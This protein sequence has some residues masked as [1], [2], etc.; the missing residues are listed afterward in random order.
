MHRSLRRHSATF[1]L[2]STLIAA[3]W[4]TASTA[5]GVV[6]L[7]AGASGSVA[8]LAPVLAALPSGFA[9]G[10]TTDELLQQPDGSAVEIQRF[11]ADSPHGKQSGADLFA[12]VLTTSGAA[13]D[14]AADSAVN[15][16]SPIGAISGST[17]YYQPPS[18]L[19]T[20]S[21]AML[22][23]QVSPQV[24]VNLGMVGFELP[25]AP[26]LRQIA[27]ALK[28]RDTG[29]A[30]ALKE[31][32]AGGASLSAAVIPQDP[33]ATCTSTCPLS[34]DINGVN[35]VTDDW[36]DNV[37]L[38]VT[39]TVHAGNVVGVWQAVVWADGWA[40]YTK[41]GVDGQFGSQTDY[42]TGNW[43]TYVG[44]VAADG[45]VGHD[46]WA[47]ADNRLTVNGNLVHFH[48][49]YNGRT[50]YFTRGISATNHYAWSWNSSPYYYTGYS[51]RQIALFTG[52]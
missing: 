23:W 26:T 32:T 6:R 27:D 25:S 22:S 36:G 19:A 40:A 50:L 4:G 31:A 10:A 13:W 46:T 49:D 39:C 52:C 16:A 20:A 21:L 3:V 45:I 12:E 8:V 14:L 51:G 35:A 11:A 18:D 43:Q 44:G 48:G 7:D 15:G 34:T 37:T 24:I 1:A 28:L 30:L 9:G 41:C 17:L 47:A 2:G 29:K 5:P 33:A 38:C 42:S